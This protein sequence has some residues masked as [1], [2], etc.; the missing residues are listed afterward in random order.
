MYINIEYE[1]I[2]HTRTSKL[3]KTHTYSRTRLVVILRCDNC[4]EVFKREKR[5]MDP[6]RLSDNYFHVCQH[7][8]SKRFAQKKGVEKRTMWELPA[9]S[10][11]SIGDL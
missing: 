6:R 2:K 11:K 4:K 8:D 1:V 3:G 10:L 7:C 5:L 9:S